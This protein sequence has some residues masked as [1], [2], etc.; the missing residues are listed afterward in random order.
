MVKTKEKTKT[1][2]RLI[3]IQCSECGHV[4]VKKINIEHDG[5]NKISE[6]DITCTQ[7]S[8]LLTANIDVVI[9]QDHFVL[10]TIKG[11]PRLSKK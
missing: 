9:S 7:C 1:K 3:T 11:I 8:T 2:E 6:I 5:K 10:R 4:F